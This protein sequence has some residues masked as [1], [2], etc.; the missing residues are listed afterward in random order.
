VT[1]D[2]LREFQDCIAILRLTNAEVLKATI[3]FVDLEYED[4]VVTV[5][6]TNKPEQ[7]KGPKNA[8]YTVK[9][10]DIVSVERVPKTA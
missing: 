7:Y 3:D 9:A 1:I 10:A 6:E 4:I 5:L 2:Q 8:A